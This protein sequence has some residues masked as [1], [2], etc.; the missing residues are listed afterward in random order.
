MAFRRVFGKWPDLL[1][2]F[3]TELSRIFGSFL[4]NDFRRAEGLLRGDAPGSVS[5]R[6]ASGSLPSSFEFWGFYEK[7]VN[8][9]FDL[10]Y[11]QRLS[12]E[13]MLEQHFGEPAV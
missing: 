3:I 4:Y 13:R 1:W 10:I 2:G 8:Q 7:S 5:G 11:N 12:Y 6:Q 9:C